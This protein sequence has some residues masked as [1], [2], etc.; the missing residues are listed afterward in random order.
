MTMPAHHSGQQVKSQSACVPTLCLPY[1]AQRTQRDSM[2]QAPDAWKQR[3]ER[4]HAR[5]AAAS[6]PR[7]PCK[8]ESREG[9]PACQQALVHKQQQQRCMGKA[10]AVARLLFGVALAGRLTF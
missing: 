5:H 7:L 3:G 2:R 10:S 6:L 8:A 1:H 4:R 9:K